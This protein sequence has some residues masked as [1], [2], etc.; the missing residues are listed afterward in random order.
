MNYIL[1]VV[2]N[3]FSYR[4]DNHDLFSKLEFRNLFKIYLIKLSDSNLY[5]C[6]SDKRKDQKGCSWF[7][8]FLHNYYWAASIWASPG[9]QSWW[10]GRG[11]YDPLLIKSMKAQVT[12][13][14]SQIYVSITYFSGWKNGMSSSEALNQCMV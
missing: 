10:N 6:I 4:D 12:L 2:F 1:F 11:C 13:F 14:R 8:S 7:C 9:C 3:M 5:H